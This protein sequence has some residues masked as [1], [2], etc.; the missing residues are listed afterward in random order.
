[1][2]NQLMTAVAFI[3]NPAM[4]PEFGWQ[5]ASNA[6]N[7]RAIPIFDIWYSESRPQ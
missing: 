6:E 1:M 7:S 2:S 3:D 5:G 4:H